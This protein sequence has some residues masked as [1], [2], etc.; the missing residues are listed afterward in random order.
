MVPPALSVNVELELGETFTIQ[1]S[2]K[3]KAIQSKK[4]V[5]GKDL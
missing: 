3:R 2:K 5:K 1:S 4:A